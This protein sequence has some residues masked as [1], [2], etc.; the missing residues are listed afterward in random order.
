M[1]RL[2]F[3]IPCATHLHVADV[4]ALLGFQTM[5]VDGL[6]LGREQPF[7]HV[8]VDE[9][10]RPGGQSTYVAQENLTTLRGGLQPVEHPLVPQLFTLFD[11]ESGCY[12][13]RPQL[14]ELYPD[15]G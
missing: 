8:L 5:K 1:T 12:L 11:A 10:D 2:C 6:P 4:P 9:R 3:G 14:R 15:D 13:P 7:Y